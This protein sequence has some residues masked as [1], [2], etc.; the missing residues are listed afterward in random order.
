MVKGAK[1]FE[2]RGQMKAI[3]LRRPIIFNGNTIKR[4]LVEID[5]INFG[6]DRKT[7]QLNI[8]RRTNFTLGEIEKFIMMLD[9]EYQFHKSFRGRVSRYEMRIDCP[10]P[11]RFLNK[12]FVIVFETN[13]DKSDEIHTITL[14]PG[15]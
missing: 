5:H 15:W 11:G 1:N 7:K 4:V 3:T 13:F 9:G 14:F 6:I 10:V 12:E 8:K 2:G